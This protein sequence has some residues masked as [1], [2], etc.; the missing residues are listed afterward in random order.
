MKTILVP[1]DF[2]KLSLNAVDAASRIAQ[3]MNAKVLVVNIVDL[4]V[5]ESDAPSQVVEEFQLGKIMLDDAT[6]KLHDIKSRYKDTEMET[7]VIFGSVFHSI[8]D[9][10]ESVDADLIIMGTQG[11]TGAEEFFLGSVAERVVRWSNVPVLTI[12]E[13]IQDVYFDNIMFVSNFYGEI[14]YNF[15]KIKSFFEPFNPKYHFV[16]VITPNSFEPTDRSKKI[17]EDF[18][19]KMEVS[20]YQ[21]Y[22]YNDYTLEEGIRHF[23]ETINQDLIVIPTHGHKGLSH[24]L[25]GSNAEKMVNHIKAPI[26]TFRIDEPKVEYGVIF[27]ELK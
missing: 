13:E 12:K 20:D 3:K 11:V 24:L 16:K 27:P 10:A 23:E 1:V 14:E 8:T 15:P 22:I 9:K 4:S 5:L 19:E 6:Q 21:I 7:E 25:F 17:M 18:A 2:S 26:M